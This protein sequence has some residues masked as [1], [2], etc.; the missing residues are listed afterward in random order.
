MNKLP[1]CI[2][3]SIGTNDWYCIYTHAWRETGT[4]S[5]DLIT[6]MCMVK[7]MDDF[8]GGIQVRSCK[9]INSKI[10]HDEGWGWSTSVLGRCSQSSEG[11]PVLEAFPYLE[12]VH[13]FDDDCSEE[14][15]RELVLYSL[16]ARVLMFAIDSGRNGIVATDR[17]DED[18]DDGDDWGTPVLGTSELME[19]INHCST[20]NRWSTEG[21]GYRYKERY[22]FLTATN[23]KMSTTN[24]FNSNSENAVAVFVSYIPH[25][26]DYH[27]DYDS[28]SSYGYVENG[29]CR[30]MEDNRDERDWLSDNSPTEEWCVG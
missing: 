21:Y 22:R 4:S 27:D 9:V 15:C 1:K 12:H 25:Y 2:L 26:S 28:D 17:V 8:C 19:A 10:S 29:L 13:Q 24:F 14:E 11:V 7:Y 6:G 16:A 20:W 5:L 30:P 3:T 23:R 18:G